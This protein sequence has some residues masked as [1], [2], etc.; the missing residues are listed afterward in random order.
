MAEKEYND[1]ASSKAFGS[2]AAIIAVVVGVYSVIAP[3]NR[4]INEADARI[5]KLETKLDEANKAL[6]VLSM[7][8]RDRSA[9]LEQ[10]VK[11]IESKQDSECARLAKLENWTTWWYETVPKNNATVEA[12]LATLEKQMELFHPKKLD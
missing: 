9:T 8:D 12:R 7:A 4:S 3:T 5:A 6:N 11:E 2:I 10:R 1:A